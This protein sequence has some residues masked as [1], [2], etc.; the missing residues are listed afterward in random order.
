[1]PAMTFAGAFERKVSFASCFSSRSACASASPSSFSRRARSA[2]AS[3]CGQRDRD[4]GVGD[5]AEGLLAGGHAPPSDRGLE[6]DAR[7]EV[8]RGERPLEAAP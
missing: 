6:L 4:F 5:A 2:A 1:M 7:G 8:R 3:T